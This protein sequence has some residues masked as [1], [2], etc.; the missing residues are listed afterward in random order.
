[1]FSSALD[2]ALRYADLGWPVFPCKP[3]KKPF[4][5][6]GFRD[7]SVEH[8]QIVE[9]WRQWPEAQVGV[10]CGAAGICVVDLDMGNGKDGIAA[11]ARLEDEHGPHWC[12]LIATTPRGGR[13][14]VYLMP[15]DPVPNGQ[16]IVETQSGIDVRGDGGYIVVPSPS[17]PGRE[18]VVGHPF[19]DDKNTGVSDITQMPEWVERMARGGRR[20]HH[21]SP[22]GQSGTE[23][24]LLDAQVAAIKRALQFIDSDPR[25]T[26][27]RVGMALKSTGAREQAYELWCGWSKTSP[28]FDPKTQVYQWNSLREFFLDGHE[29]TI[30]TLFHIA[31]QGG[32]QP[33]LEDELAAEAPAEPPDV[34]VVEPPRK[35]PFPR[36]LM[37]V[38]GL[39]GD[40]AAWMV[41]SSTRQQPAMCLASAI[42]MMGAV[43]GRRVATPTDLRTNVYCLGIGETACGKDPGVR[44]PQLLL[45]RAGL[46]S[47]VGPGEWK[48]DSGLRAALLDAPAHLACVDEFTKVLAALSGARIPAHLLELW[49]ASNSVHLSPA[50]A[51]RQLNKPVTIEQPNLCVYGTG[52]PEEL[53]SSLDR[54]ALQDGFLNRILVFFA[55]DQLP[56]RRKVGRADPPAELVERL[57]GL[58]KVLAEQAG[59]LAHRP[60]AKV[61][62][63]MVAMSTTAEDELERI[64]SENE[65]RIVAMRARGEPL[66]DLWVRT[67]A[68]VAKLALIRAVSDDPGRAIELADV[69]WAR[70]VVVWCLERTMAEAESRVADSQQEALTKRVLRVIVE[71]GVGGLTGSQL[72]KRTQWLRRA[73]RKDIVATLI[74]TGDVV[75][76]TEPTGTKPTTIYVAANLANATTT[77][78]PG[79]E[80]AA[81]G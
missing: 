35:R 13:H 32:Y 70:D 74:E 9:W 22:A 5:A 14:L 46:Q 17:S 55:D 24:V 12:G 34:P 48:S 63:R 43:L 38:P 15:E 30:A 78:A 3:D 62:A 56:Q 41:E 76:A 28:K 64:E 18:W 37:N 11:F 67:G 2:A 54:G 71:A 69:C 81:V 7:A 60:E 58:A 1:M 39:V 23:M 33:V 8:A 68:H 52:V 44:L 73:D 26:W 27:I 77:S 21:A 29:V 50:Y 51:N 6:H 66:S 40:V 47:L 4:T 20:V 80:A 53:F 75:T 16:D 79:A 19:E 72:T 25:D 10:A 36:E 59:N 57:A 61:D 45:S 49:A 42:A 65:A 31:K